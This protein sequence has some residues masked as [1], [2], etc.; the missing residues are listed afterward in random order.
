MVVLPHW[1]TQY[2]HAPVAESAAR[3]PPAGRARG[4]TWSWAATRTGCRA[5]DR[6]GDAVVVHS[7]GN[8][9]F[10]MD[11]MTQTMEGVTLTATFWGSRLVGVTLSPYVL[12]GRFRAASR[13][14][15]AGP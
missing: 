8:F 11:F 9:V 2:T 5:I 4:P 12:D 10:D 15:S 6:V 3:G 7:L 13:G 1:G 14:W